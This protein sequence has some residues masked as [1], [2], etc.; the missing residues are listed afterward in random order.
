MGGHSQTKERANREHELR[1][2]PARQSPTLP[3]RGVWKRSYGCATKAP[4]DERGGNRHAQPKAT[5]PH[6]YST[7]SGPLAKSRCSSASDDVDGSPP[8]P[9]HDVRVSRKESD[10]EASFDDWIGYSEVRFSGARRR[11][12]GARG[13]A[14]EIVPK[15]GAGGLRQTAEMPG[16]HRGVRLV[17]L[18]GPGVE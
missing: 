11:R 7:L 3:M 12:G 9:Q 17:A 1:P 8:L 2:K 4:P 15:P 5:A 14:A 10:D 13:F 6:S 16:W 18:L